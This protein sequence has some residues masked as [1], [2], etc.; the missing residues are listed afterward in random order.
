VRRVYSITPA[1]KRRFFD[2]MMHLGNYE[3]DFSDWFRIRL[4][5]FRHIAGEQRIAIC[6]DYKHYTEMIL[7]DTWAKIQAVSKSP[8]MK[9]AERADVL[10]VLEH[11]QRVAA[12]ELQ[13]LAA[14]VDGVN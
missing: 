8:D 14:V 1:G 3:N 6:R 2:L 11:E 5:N 9:P 7:E 13:W 10:R 4:S 12:G